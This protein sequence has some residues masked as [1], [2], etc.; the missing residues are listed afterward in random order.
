[1]EWK[2]KEIGSG[3]G[4]PKGTTIKNHHKSPNELLQ[5]KLLAVKERLKVS[6]ANAIKISKQDFDV[7]LLMRI[8][9]TQN[10]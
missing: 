3:E 4:F 9:Y 8:N 1:M 10:Q 6:M 5:I 7:K 2:S